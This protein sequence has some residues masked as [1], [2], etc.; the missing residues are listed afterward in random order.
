MLFVCLFVFLF[1]SEGGGVLRMKNSK[2]T[3][4]KMHIS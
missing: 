3:D 4:I 1:L 2:S